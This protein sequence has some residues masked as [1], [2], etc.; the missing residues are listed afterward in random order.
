MKISLLC[1]QVLAVGPL[2]MHRD[3]HLPRI[4]VIYRS[5]LSESYKPLQDP[6]IGRC[7]DIIDLDKDHTTRGGW[8]TSTARNIMAKVFPKPRRCW[9][10]TGCLVTIRHND[11]IIQF[12]LVQLYLHWKPLHSETSRSFTWSPTE[13]VSDCFW[14][15]LPSWCENTWWKS[16]IGFDEGT[17]HLWLLVIF[18]LLFSFLL[19][20][21]FS[22]WLT[23]SV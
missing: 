21:F 7:M 16:S 17:F 22:K 4:L 1:V 3:T 14:F 2:I 9:L 19:R 8:A 5:E 18:M 23:P 20:V 13:D 10:P 11:E 15:Q 6:L 12:S